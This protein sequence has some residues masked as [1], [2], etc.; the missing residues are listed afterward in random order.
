[1]QQRRSPTTVSQMMAQIQDLQNKVNSLS[2]AREFCDPESGSSSGATHFPH[3]NPTIL[4]SKTLPRC[5]SGLPRKTQNCTG[6]M[7]NVFERPPV[8]EWLP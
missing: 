8:Q 1:M 7:G 5:E 3:Q 4:S 6:I 2:D